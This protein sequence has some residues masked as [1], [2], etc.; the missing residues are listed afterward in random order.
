MYIRDDW[1]ENVG[2]PVPTTTEE[3][4]ALAKAF[5]EQDPD[6][7]GEDDTVGIALGNNLT[8]GYMGFTGIANSYGAYPGAWIERDGKLVYGSVQPEMK[9]ALIALRDAVENGYISPEFAA[10]DNYAASQIAVNSGSGINF[11]KF[12]V[13]TW[14]LPATYD[15]VEGAE[16]GV[17]A[18]PSDPECEYQGTIATS[19]VTNAYMVN[20][21]FEY[22]SALIKMYNYFM[23]KMYG[24]TS[25]EVKYHSHDGYS[26]HMWSPVR[27][28]M[29]NNNAE[30]NIQVTKAIDEKD[31]SYLLTSE[32]RATYESCMKFLDG[33]MSSRMTYKLF[34]GEGSTFGIENTIVDTK[35]YVRDMF[36][37]AD[38]PEMLRRMPILKDSE[39]TMILEIIT[40]SVDIDY[41]DEFVKNWHELGGET[42]TYEV[43]EWYKNN[44]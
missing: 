32:Q 2:L 13:L 34:Y 11:G 36:Y 38:T 31:E 18:I 43:N 40:G 14:P 33:D 24:E 21:E 9:T 37:G 30:Q 1:R 19:K 4:M 22:P 29:G 42:I 17:Y 6:G 25:D 26:I 27:G 12:W 39:S 15:L 5:T 8:E 7:N 3:L 35:Y 28:G 23:E 10:T 41:F 20:A 16:W 44:K